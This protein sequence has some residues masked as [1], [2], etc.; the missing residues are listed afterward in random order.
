M[1]LLDRIGFIKHQ[2]LFLIPNQDSYKGS[3]FNFCEIPGNNSI[4]FNFICYGS[5]L[6][7]WD[8][9]FKICLG[10]KIHPSPTPLERIGLICQVITNTDLTAFGAYL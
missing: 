10:K 2:F 6:T 9:F 8:T 4:S 1:L 7:I 5:L 3:R